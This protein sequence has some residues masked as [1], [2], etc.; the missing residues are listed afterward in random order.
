MRRDARTT[1][2]FRLQRIF[3][4]VREIIV[5]GERSQLESP[6][7]I[8][9]LSLKDIERSS[10]R[11]VGEL[12]EHVPGVDI[13]D[14]SGGSGQKR[15]SIRGSR[16]NQVMVVMDGVPLNDPLVGDADL[17]LIPLSMVKEIRIT[18]TGSSHVY[19][20][21]ALSGVIDIVTKSNPV[22]VVHCRA[23]YGDF[24]A[25]G[26]NPGF[27]GT[28]KNFSYL[29]QYDH[30]KDEGTFEFEYRYYTWGYILLNK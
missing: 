30:M 12:L 9:L 11:T 17:S 27:S 1:V 28:W 18:K 23:T 15:V 3:I 20:S 7:F 24:Q 14:E 4:P 22:D 19:G 13:I 16:S 6:E 10:A 5:E 26:I 25:F 2:N 21:G 29:G 8:E